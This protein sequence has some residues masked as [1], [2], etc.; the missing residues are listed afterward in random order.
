MRCLTWLDTIPRQKDPVAGWQE[1]S[2]PC[3]RAEDQSDKSFCS[4]CV[5]PKEFSFEVRNLF[6]CFPYFIFGAWPHA[7]Q[8]LACLI[9]H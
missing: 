8:I 5:T 7:A 2:A 6:C 3:Q 9:A 1:F 4:F